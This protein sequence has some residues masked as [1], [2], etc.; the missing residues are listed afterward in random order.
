M[1]VDT[2]KLFTNDMKNVKI[3]CAGLKWQSKILFA[4]KD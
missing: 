3:P 4:I 2:D 1:L